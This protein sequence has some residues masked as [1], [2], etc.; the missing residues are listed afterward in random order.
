MPVCQC[1]NIF[2]KH[3][4][5]HILCISHTICYTVLKFKRYRNTNF[6]ILFIM[7]VFD[8]KF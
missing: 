2:I 4:N 3:K 5:I 7:L 1:V 6:N 8:L